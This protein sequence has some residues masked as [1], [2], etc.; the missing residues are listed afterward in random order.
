MTRT[1]TEWSVEQVVG[2]FKG[3]NRPDVEEVLD[4]LAALGILAGYKSKGRPP[5]ET[6][7]HSRV[8]HCM[9][10]ERIM[11]RKPKPEHPAKDGSRDKVVPRPASDGAGD[12]AL[13]KRN[14]DSVQPAGVSLSA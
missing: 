9:R 14:E 5:L 1:Q 12:P 11:K 2:A 3:A 10:R 8:D 13:A 4:S 7:P 6:H